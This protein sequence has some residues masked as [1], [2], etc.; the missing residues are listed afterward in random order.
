MGGPFPRQTGSVI[1]NIGIL[2]G[3][4]TVAEFFQMSVPAPG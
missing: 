3:T 1:A 2:K 4:F